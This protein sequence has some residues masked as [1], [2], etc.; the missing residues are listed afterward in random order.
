MYVFM[1]ICTVVAIGV[2]IQPMPQLV[3]AS[4]GC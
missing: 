3:L 2:V 1:C 4:D